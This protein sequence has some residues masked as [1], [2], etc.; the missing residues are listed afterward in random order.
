M[1]KQICCKCREFVLWGILGVLWSEVSSWLGLDW[2]ES[3]MAMVFGIP[4]F[5]LAREG[6]RAL[7]DTIATETRYVLYSLRAGREKE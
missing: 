2:G 6:I 1:V 4:L 7:R 3:L 5:Y